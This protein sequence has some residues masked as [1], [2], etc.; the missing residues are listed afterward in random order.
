MYAAL[1]LV[2]FTVF[3]PL[4]FLASATTA[5]QG[6]YPSD[7]T[8][9][10]ACVQGYNSDVSNSS[11]CYSGSMSQSAQQ[12]CLAGWQAGRNEKGVPEE[13]KQNSTSENTQT[14][15]GAVPQYGTGTKCGAVRTSY[16]GCSADESPDNIEESTVWSLLTI[17]LN[18]AIAT[19][20]IA[21][22]AGIV[23]GA[24]MYTSAQDNASQTQ[25]AKDIIRNVIIGLVLFVCF[26]A[27]M[28]AI[29]PGGVF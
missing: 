14:E 26:W 2:M 24:L 27:I 12:A 9:R 21:A 18:V 13:Q 15:P 1:S 6:L 28:Q 19:I 4:T 29:I 7:A 23:Y 8:G 20:G 11:V 5:C 10:N 16:L 22:V 17:I 3:Y 25:K